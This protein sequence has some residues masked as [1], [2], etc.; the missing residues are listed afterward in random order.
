MGPKP[1]YAQQARKVLAACEKNLTDAVELNYDQHNPFDLCAASYT[2]IYRG[3]AV[4]KC[5]LSGACYLPE[6]KGQVCHV[7]KSTKIGAD[8]MGLR[9]SAMQFR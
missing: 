5:P 3:K 9:I 2:P 7:T 4:E 1:E 6:F 8:V